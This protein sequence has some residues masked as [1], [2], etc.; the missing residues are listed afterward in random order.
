MADPLAQVADDFAPA[1]L[2]FFDEKQ[3]Q[4]IMSRYADA[5]TDFE[6]R[7]ATQQYRLAE[8]R[9]RREAERVERDRLLADRDDIEY[10][11]KQ[12]ARGAR[13]QFIGDIMELSEDDEDFDSKIIGVLKDAPPAVQ[14]DETIRDIL[15][16]KRDKAE[17]MR[18]EKVRLG[19][20]T[21]K[22]EYGLKK[23]EASRRNS[24]LW[25]YL[26]PEDLQSLPRD[27]DTGEI[28]REMGLSRAVERKRAAEKEDFSAKTEVRAEAAK[29]VLRVSAMSKE[30]KALHD[31]TKDILINNDEAFPSAVEN[32][33]RK[34]ILEGN[35]ISSDATL[36]QAGGEAY[37]KAVA[38]D[39][40]KWENEVL[41]AKKAATPEEYINLRTFSKAEKDAGAE[42][43]PAAVDARTRVW[44]FA[45]RLDGTG[46]EKALPATEETPTEDKFTVGQQYRDANGNTATYKGG[47]KWE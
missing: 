20:E 11:E 28:D 21:Q 23:S 39:K 45:H 8:E 35:T 2:N 19:M 22:Q 44:E 26:T 38:W 30:E 17:R 41:T 10:E 33:R 4:N 42:L 43:S 47:G 18:Q 14:E 25:G 7:S 3:A 29:D 40:K 16:V 12:A 27:P 46:K 34:L 24:A 6:T 31:E 36:A 13:S 32:L 15:K 37:R 1:P 5:R 9:D